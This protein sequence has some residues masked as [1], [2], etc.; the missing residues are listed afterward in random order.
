MSPKKDREGV[1]VHREYGQN[2]SIGELDVITGAV[3]P[4]TVQAIRQTELVRIPAALFDAISARHPAT[5]LQ[6]MRLIARRVRKA[7]G[8]QSV[9]HW[10]PS[11]ELR[12]DRNLSAF[13]TRQLALAGR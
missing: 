8:E 1:D 7:V 13:S 3:R 11:Q 12:A 9:Q 5:T 6:F 2:D 4:K 10:S